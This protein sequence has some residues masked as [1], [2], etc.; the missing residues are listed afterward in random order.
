MIRRCIA[1]TDQPR[2]TNS[3]ASQSSSSGCVGFL[4]IAPKLLG[5]PAI[6]RPKCPCQIRLTIDRAMMLLRG[7][8]SHSAKARRRPDAEFGIVFQASAAARSF[9]PG[10]A[11]RTPGVTGSVGDATLPPARIAVASSLP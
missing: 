1:L 2:A 7:L 9:E 5:L 8:A 4:P 10:K 11:L 6:P 3:E